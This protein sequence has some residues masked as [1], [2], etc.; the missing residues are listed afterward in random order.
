MFGTLGA[1]VAIG[2][3][4][5]GFVG[6]D[7]TSEPVF[8]RSPIAFPGTTARPEA[9][10]TV[11]ADSPNYMA[12]IDSLSA[13]LDQEVAE[14]RHLESQLAALE[15]Q[16]ETLQER[17]GE[18]TSPSTPPR[19]RFGR[20]R[21][22]V[23]I[24]ADR[25]IQAG[26][27]PGEAALLAQRLDESAIA[28]LY[29]RDRAIREGWIDSQRYADAVSELPGSPESIR[30]DLG[31]GS[32]DRYL[33]AVGRP[34]RVVVGRIMEG[35]AAQRAGLQPGDTILRYSG[36]RLFSMSDVTEATTGGEFGESVSVE[37]MRDEQIVTVVMSRGPMGVILGSARVDPS[38]GG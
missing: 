18:Q 10:V 8:D 30:R 29:L 26:F 16:I 32:Y 38:P 4:G 19:R 21:G 7:T 35:S 13:V 24:S 20:S 1:G 6:D 2:I 11:S 14:R 23:G 31:E 28:G 15:T 27:D 17:L 36:Q 22:P 33:F 25:L 12:M 5:S 3:V 9:G 37:V 34:N